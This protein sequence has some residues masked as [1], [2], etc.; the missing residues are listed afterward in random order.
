MYA[1]LEV[2]RV[3]ALASP[4]LATAPWR[5]RT[6]N[7]D[8]DDIFIFMFLDFSGAEIVDTSAN[9]IF[10]GKIRTLPCYQPYMTIYLMFQT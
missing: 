8:T 7:H 10:M 4:V 2:G 3:T 6:P 5:R 9:S 1:K